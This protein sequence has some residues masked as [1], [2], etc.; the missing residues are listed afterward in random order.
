MG[1]NANILSDTSI[2]CETCG[3]EHYPHKYSRENPRFCSQRC[4]GDSISQKVTIICKVCSKPFKVPPSQVGLRKCC[5]RAC[6]SQEHI[7]R[8]TG[9]NNPNYN[10]GVIVECAECSQKIRRN[11]SQLGVSERFFCDKYC[12]GNWMSENNTNNKN[13]NWKKGLYLTHSKRTNKEYQDWRLAVYER[14]NFTCQACGYDKG[15]ILQAHHIKSF[16]FFKEL[17]YDIKN[18]ITLCKDCHRKVHTLIRKVA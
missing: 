14:D 6:S 2:V 13:P 3:K 17:R 9:T 11:V 4:F 12:M 15:G 16:T 5:S 1:R 18:G 8:F 7:K 10:G